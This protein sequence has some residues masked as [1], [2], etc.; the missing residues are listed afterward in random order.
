MY[1]SIYSK[2]EME[3]EDTPTTS[4][5]HEFITVFQSGVAIGTDDIKM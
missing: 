2:E 3:F 4:L 5:Y 1:I